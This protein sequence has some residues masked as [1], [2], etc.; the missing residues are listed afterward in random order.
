MMREKTRG[1]AGAARKFDLGKELP[2]LY[3]AR[4]EPAVVEMPRLRCLA[5]DGEGS[6]RSKA[7]QSAMA[8]LYGVAY[9]VKFAGKP[10]GHDFKVAALEGQWW[11]DPREV[12]RLENPGDLW[13][14]PQAAWRWRLLMPVPGFVDAAAVKAA[15]AALAKKRGPGAGASVR[16]VS[17]HEGRCVQAL[18]VGPYGDEERTIEKMRALA[19]REGLRARGEHHEIY[20]SDPRRTKPERLRTILR[21]PVA[22]A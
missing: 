6:P 21:Q 19:A 9:A 16:L 15:K 3:R 8:E 7:F 1:A 14:A 2:Q 5:V 17:I 10:E 20:L 18:H 12:K 13:R 22:R 11:V 4:P